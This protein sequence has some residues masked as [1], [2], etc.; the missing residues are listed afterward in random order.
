MKWYGGALTRPLHSV[1]VGRMNFPV[2]T[3]PGTWSPSE[4][5]RKINVVID[6]AIVLRRDAEPYRNY[7]GAS[8]L[9]D[10]CDRR[11]VFE[12]QDRPSEALDAKATRIFDTGHMFETLVASWLCNAG[13]DLL[14]LDPDTGRP[15]EFQIADGLVRGHADGVIM[16][17]PEIGVPYPLLWECKSLNESS[18]TDLARRGLKEAKP[19]Y[20]AQV[21]TYLL[22]LGYAS[23]M[24]TA[25]NK[26]NAAL[27][28]EIIP[29]VESEARWLSARAIRLVRLAATNNLPPRIEDARECRRC[30]FAMMCGE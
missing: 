14:D 18:W 3:I 23:C 21:Q 11:L 7:L 5:C 12:C 17:G 20:F 25:I 27:Y 8:I 29:F 22:H 19:L 16:S 1:R 15:F 26:N 9:G 6:Q 28:H 10:P 13:F 24:L 2:I 4:T 30:R